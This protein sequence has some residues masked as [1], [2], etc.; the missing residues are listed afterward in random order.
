MKDWGDQDWKTKSGK[1]SSKTGERYLPAKAIDALTDGEYKKTSA[2]KRKAMKDGKQFSKQ[3]KS[4]AKKTAKFRHESWDDVEWTDEK[5]KKKKD[6]GWQED[7]EWDAESLKPHSVEISR[8]TNSQKKL[9]AVFYDSEGKKMKTTHFGQRGASDYTKHGDKERM[10]RYL[11]RHGG[12]TT[13]STKEDWKDPT[14]AGSLSRWILW[15]KP[16]LEASFNDYKK[17]FGLKGELTV[18]KSAEDV[19][20]ELAI[21]MFGSTLIGFMAGAIISHI[22]NR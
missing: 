19:T 11:E 20:E 4:I 10:E 1:K 18:S 9:M 14:T 21:G 5:P 3:P 6:D 15:N 8:S 16:D 22:A 17:R 13:T 7:V 12:G 2:K